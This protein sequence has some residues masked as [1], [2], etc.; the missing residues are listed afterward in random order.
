MS[1][2]IVTFVELFKFVLYFGRRPSVEE[3]AVGRLENCLCKRRATMTKVEFQ[4]ISNNFQV[5]YTY[6]DF[7]Q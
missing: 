5:S 6:G 2:I 3:Q 7:S 1:L 4:H